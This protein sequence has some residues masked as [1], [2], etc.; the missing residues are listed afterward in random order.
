M[1]SII[2]GIAHSIGLHGCEEECL[3]RQVVLM[4]KES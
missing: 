2:F 4:V 1:R 3:F